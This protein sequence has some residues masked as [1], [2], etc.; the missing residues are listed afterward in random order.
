MRATW[1][2][3][4]NTTGKARKPPLPRSF[5]ATSAWFIRQRSGTSGLPPTPRKSRRPS[6]SSSRAKPP[7]LRPDTILESWLYETTRLTALSF[8]R[9]ERRRQFREQEAYMQ[10]TL[11]ESADASTWNQLAPLLDEAM[12]R[13]GKNDRD[14]VFAA[15]FQG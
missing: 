9:G 8:R 11:Q 3:C 2:C 4:G 13:L 7:D 12:A 10:S 1:N 5:N 14:A 15:F 6:S